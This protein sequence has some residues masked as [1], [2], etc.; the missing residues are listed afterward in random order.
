MRIMRSL[1]CVLLMVLVVATS[2][3]C[4]A[5]S[6]PTKPIRLIVPF[7]PG[8]G[9]DFVA[10]LLQPE[11]SEALGKPVLVDNKAGAGGTIGTAE[12]A[13]S[14]PDG[15][16]LLLVFA[17]HAV[18]PIVHKGLPYDIWRDLTPVSLIVT[19]PMVAAVSVALP[20]NGIQE[21]IAYA[22]ANP[23]QVNY[24]SSGVGNSEHLTGAL[25]ALRTGTSMVHVPY[26]GGAHAMTDLIAG[27]LHIFWASPSTSKTLL[28]SGRVKLLGQAVATRNSSL[29]DLKTVSEQG[30]QGFEASLWIGMVAPARTP[31]EIIG[32]VHAALV[33]AANTPRVATIFR[34]RGYDLVMN[35]PEEF[36][37]FRRAENTKWATLIEKANI[38]LE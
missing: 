5:Q 34:D 16:T 11:F 4:A 33:K 30:V 14:T 20:A 2:L 36:E 18:E 1:S 25:F 28:Q 15:Y 37:T 24:G 23:G 13:R 26:K 9:M 3:N 6:Y 35:T 22:R 19:A 38:L 29:P 31:R 10:R 7:P 17:S 32:R 27:R 8:A 21:L 12:A